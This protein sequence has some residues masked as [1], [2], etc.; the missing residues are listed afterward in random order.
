MSYLNV[1]T[2]QT[3]ALGNEITAVQLLG[4][5]MTAAVLLVEALGGGWRDTALPSARDV[6][7]RT[8]PGEHSPASDQP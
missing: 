5:R 4:R 6:T 1:V 3:I 8:A 2:T 7:Q